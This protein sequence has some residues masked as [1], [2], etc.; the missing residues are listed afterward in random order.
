[1]SGYIYRRGFWHQ[2]S[3]DKRRY[4]ISL[5]FFKRM[6]SVCCYAKAFEDCENVRF[7]SW[8]SSHDSYK[9]L[10][11]IVMHIERL[12]GVG[13]EERERGG[14][15][16]KKMKRE[17]LKFRNLIDRFRLKLIFHSQFWRWRYDHMVIFSLF[18][19]IDYCY[20]CSNYARACSC[21]YVCTTIIVSWVSTIV[22][23]SMRL[24]VVL[25]H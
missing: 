23:Q 10:Y 2:Y 1:M 7:R 24:I 14:G 13:R 18:S 11:S 16:A 6:D 21:V 25:C 9:S 12:D 17:I 5:S 19:G 8:L 15:V 22:T 20:C 3:G 4:L